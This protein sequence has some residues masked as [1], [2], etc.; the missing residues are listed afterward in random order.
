TDATYDPNG[1]NFYGRIFAAV[2]IVPAAPGSG[3][4][5]LTFNGGGGSINR[6][7]NIIIVDILEFSGVDTSSPVVQTVLQ[8]AG[9]G[10]SHTANF[11]V[12]PDVAN[13]VVSHAGISYDA[14]HT[15]IVPPTGYTE[16]S[17][18]DT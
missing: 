5:T 15:N 9:S 13:A 10:T 2:A 16:V 3:T 17:D 12:S 7:R 8:S 18:Y 14:D 1:S 11:G 6:N 4:I